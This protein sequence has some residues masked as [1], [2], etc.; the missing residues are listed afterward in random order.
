MCMYYTWLVGNEIIVS[1]RFFNL[2]G[3]TRT[4]DHQ[5]WATTMTGMFKI[6]HCD[7]FYTYTGIDKRLKNFRFYFS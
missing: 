2:G 1:T 3:G 7:H 5:C 4:Y 6:H